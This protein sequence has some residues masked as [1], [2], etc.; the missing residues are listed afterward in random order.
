[1]NSGVAGSR[2]GEFYAVQQAL[3]SVTDDGKSV[4]ERT[5]IKTAVLRETSTGQSLAS[6]D[7]SA[8][9]GIQA[10]DLAAVAVGR[11]KERR[12]DSVVWEHGGEGFRKGLVGRPY[13]RRWWRIP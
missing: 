5:H 10:V 9:Q 7:L 2:S 3:I 12:R 6:I 11:Q 1:M 4:N 13:C 8:Q